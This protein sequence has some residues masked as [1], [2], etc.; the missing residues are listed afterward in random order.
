M[1][2]T[3]EGV[4]VIAVTQTSNDW[5]GDVKLSDEHVEYRWITPSE[6]MNL[7]TGDDGGFLKDSMKA[8]T[9]MI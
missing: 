2:K 3:Y 8:Y 5:E 7:E 1:G 9:V 6:F 4:T